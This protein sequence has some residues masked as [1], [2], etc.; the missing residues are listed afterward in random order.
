MNS[1][2]T[3][4]YN[5]NGTENGALSPQP[6]PYNNGGVPQYPY[7]LYPPYQQPGPDGEPPKPISFY[8]THQPQYYMSSNKTSGTRLIVRGEEVG[9]V[10]VVLL[11]WVGS[12]MLFIKGWGKIRTLEPSRSKFAVARRPSCS[13]A[14]NSVISNIS[15]CSKIHLYKIQ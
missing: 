14:D 10:L 3:D 13:T 15:V 12:I 1:S 7:L 6:N 9:I 11:I 8:D 5:G 4:G 2:Y